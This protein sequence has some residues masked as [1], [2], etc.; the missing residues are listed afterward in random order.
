[1]RKSETAFDL[2][3][4]R[5]ELRK[6]EQQSAEPE[7]WHNPEAAQ[8]LLSEIARRK[9]ELEPWDEL[10]RRAE[11]A[12]VLA[13][14]AQQENDAAAAR[15]A[16]QTLERLRGRLREMETALLLG[17]E[18]DHSSA[19]ISINAGAGGTESCDWVDMLARMYFRWAQ[20]RGYSVQII[21]RTPGEAAGSRSITAILSGPYAYGYLKAER[22]V[23][24]LVRLSPFDAAHRRHTSFAS[25]DVIPEVEREQEVEIGPDEIRVD[26]FRATGA[27]GQHVNKTDSAVRI[28]HLPTGIV[29]QS[30]NERSQHQNRANAMKVL[31]ARL[32]ERKIQEQERKL[33]QMRGEPTEIAWGNQ[34]RSYVLQPYVMVKDHRTGFQTSNAEAVL[35][36]NIDDLISAYLERR[37]GRASS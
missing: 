34:I 30:Q 26:T 16:Q 12:Q 22:G 19:I 5:S 7:L 10:T 1:L 24:R 36:G 23:H 33:A 27:G 25:V 11:D 3:Q 31:K 4:R 9:Q 8:Q 17:G 37:S 15:E 20:N 14:L 35:E 29:V 32:L 21:D 6:L 13:E 18:Y 28:T 2:E